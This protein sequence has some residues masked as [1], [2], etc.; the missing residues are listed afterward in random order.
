M[1]HFFLLS[2]ASAVF[3]GWVTVGW[4]AP[5]DQ[6][7]NNWQGQSSQQ[8]A[9]GGPAAS[10]NGHAGQGAAAAF[11]GAPS[12]KGRPSGQP[13]GAGTPTFQTRQ[14]QQHPVQPQ[15]PNFQTQVQ[16]HYVQPQTPTV[17]TQRTTQGF[18][19]QPNVGPQNFNPR[20]GAPGYHPG[21]Q[22]P[23]YSPQYFPHTFNM[24]VRYHWRGGSWRGPQGWYYRPWYY[25]Q[26]L[27][28]AWLGSSWWIND[29]WYYGLPVPPYGYEWIR[30]GPDAL[31]VDVNNG[32]V[33]EV[34]PG[35]F[36]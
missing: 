32:R 14:V 34:I 8:H 17:Q 23:Q 16:Q 27:P 29:Y 1:K 7:Q 35:I 3:L 13:A 36:Y 20:F 30:N 12:A 19:G 28:F 5:S 24:G 25:G 18:T 11:Q 9:K 10:N 31:L 4:A 6:Q 33:V 15:T 21:G 2:A 26:I 22:R